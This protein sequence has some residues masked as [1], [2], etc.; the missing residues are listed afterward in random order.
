MNIGLTI[1]GY[2]VAAILGLFLL[3][4]NKRIGELETKLDVQVQETREAADANDSNI[5][6]IVELVEANR[7]LAAARK[8]DAERSKQEIV[9]RDMA[10]IVAQGVAEQERRKRLEILKST[11]NCDTYASLVVADIC[12]AFA[13]ELRERSRAP[14]SH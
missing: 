7:R 14:G 9:L 12:P 8:A 2:V 11:E 13:L 4:A 6:T 5:L 10:L 1:G 3:S